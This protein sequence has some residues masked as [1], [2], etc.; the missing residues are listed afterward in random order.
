MRC[1]GA[2]TSTA[3]C[4]SISRGS[5]PTWQGRSRKLE[6]AGVAVLV[7]GDE[8]SRSMEARGERAGSGVRAMAD[9]ADRRA[10]PTARRS[11]SRVSAE[12]PGS[13]LEEVRARVRRAVPGS[14]TWLSMWAARRSPSPVRR[15][16]RHEG[17][18]GDRAATLSRSWPSREARWRLSPI[19]MPPIAADARSI[20]RV[21]LGLVPYA[22][23]PRISSP[24]RVQTLTPVDRDATK[25]TPADLTPAA[26]GGRDS[27][28]SSST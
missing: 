11:T 24:H 5:A 8:K 4:W 10:A 16:R 6:R 2:G 19:R 13:S 15:L 28:L 14:R 9:A 3:L 7:V 12:G 21:V 27:P 18:V 25:V 23:R 20:R 17:R 1:A 26:Q 22:R